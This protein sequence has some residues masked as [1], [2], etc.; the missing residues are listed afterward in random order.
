MSLILGAIAAAATV[1][2]AIVNYLS[3]KDADK[4]K[5][6]ERSKLENALAN[7]QKPDF[8]PEDFT[9]DL[10]KVVSKYVPKEAKLIQEV[11]PTVVKGDSADAKMGRDAEKAALSALINKGQQGKT[12]ETEMMLNQAT[13][14]A[15]A[16]NRMNEASL[17]ESLAR[18]GAAPGSGTDLA[19]RM[20][21][22]AQSANAMAGASQNTAMELERQRLAALM[23]GAQLGGNIR[24]ADVNMETTNADIINQFNNR[25]ANRANQVEQYNVGTS[26]DAQKYNVGNEQAVANA[27]VGASNQAKADQRANAWK[28]ADFEAN[29]L[30]IQTGQSN[31]RVADNTATQQANAG[32]VSAGAGAIAQGAQAYGDYSAAQ[33]QAATD[34]KYRSDLLAL[35]RAKLD[36]LTKGTK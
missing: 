26:N 36:A 2:G 28:S 31:Q 6:A 7:L 27:N 4:L 18:Q 21:E 23:Q 17:R 32:I 8:K 12:L 13:Q 34:S 9:P 1:G 15:N 24:Q 11:N 10:Y 29:K 19:M 25:V 35:E 20:A 30:G 14:A 3:S 33:N 22:N 16:Q 5:A